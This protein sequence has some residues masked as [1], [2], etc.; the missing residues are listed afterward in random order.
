MEVTSLIQIN[1]PQHLLAQA[2]NWS[3]KLKSTKI[4][5]SSD[6]KVTVKMTNVFNDDNDFSVGK[7][8]RM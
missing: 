6:I 3:C 1:E 7:Y 8:S 5:N 2:W 4:D